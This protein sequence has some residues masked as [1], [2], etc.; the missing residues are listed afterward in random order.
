MLLQK[1][2]KRE[3]GELRDIHKIHGNN[4]KFVKGSLDWKIPWIS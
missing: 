1:K 4:L 3:N 2:I